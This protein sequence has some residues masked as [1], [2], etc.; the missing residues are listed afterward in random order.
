MAQS[1]ISTSDDDT[2]MIDQVN[3]S[4]TW[5]D[6]EDVFGQQR[7]EVRQTSNMVDKVTQR[8]LE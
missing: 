4:E 6:T 7:L 1:R 3:L 5:A 2:M 8:Y